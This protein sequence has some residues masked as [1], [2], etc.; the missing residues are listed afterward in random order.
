MFVRVLLIVGC[1]GWL[2]LLVLVTGTAWTSSG[3]DFALVLSQPFKLGRMDTLC[4]QIC[5][6]Q[7]LTESSGHGPPHPT[8]PDHKS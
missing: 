8:S 7:A 2:D 3:H 5:G 4:Q 1:S 6:S